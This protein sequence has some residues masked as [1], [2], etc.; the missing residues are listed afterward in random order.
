MATILLLV[1]FRRD[2]RCNYLEFGLP[3]YIRSQIRCPHY[4][5][6][7]TLTAR[8]PT[9]AKYTVFTASTLLCSYPTS[10]ATAAHHQLSFT[11]FGR[12]N[13]IDSITEHGPQAVFLTVADRLEL[14]LIVYIFTIPY[15]AHAVASCKR[16]YSNTTHG[17]N[18]MCIFPLCLCLS[19]RPSVCLSTYLSAL[20]LSLCLR[21]FSLAR[22][23][24]VL[25]LPVCFSR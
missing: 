9:S 3:L 4:G 8:L 17:V 16:I 23:L 25:Y 1:L 7:T 18:N 21:L 19:V 2:R 24:C 11:S 22:S 14:L 12:V 5:T 10:R 15:Q 20:S 6:S 13:S